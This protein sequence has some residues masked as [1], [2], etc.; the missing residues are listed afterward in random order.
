MVV[1]VATIIL[2]ESATKQ[3]SSSGHYDSDK[4]CRRLISATL[5]YI[6]LWI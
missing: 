3:E 1:L 6:T 4:V 5:R 2:L